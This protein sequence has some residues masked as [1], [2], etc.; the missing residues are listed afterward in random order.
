M[1]RL[2]KMFSSKPSSPESI[3]LESGKKQWDLA[4]LKK[5]SNRLYLRAF[6][7]VIYDRLYTASKL[8]VYYWLTVR[9]SNR[10]VPEVIKRIRR[11]H[12]S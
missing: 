11:D 1:E 6:K 9:K 4:G 2:N 7:K 5:E 8:N 10:K 12:V 3:N